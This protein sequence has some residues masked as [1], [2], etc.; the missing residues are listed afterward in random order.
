MDTR[1]MRA[2]LAGAALLTATLAIGAPPEAAHAQ[3]A[4]QAAQPG[5][6]QLSEEKLQ[7][8]AALFTA[9]TAARDEFQAQKARVHEEQARDRLR[10]EMDE[11]LA[12]LY[13]EHG[14]SQEEYDS[15][16]FLVSI[17]QAAR[18]RLDSILAARGGADGG[19][20]D[21]TDR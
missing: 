5:T 4:V 8:Y 18:T 16:T 21:G 2:R 15:I 19:D 9:I 11:R 14:M 7:Q 1:S 13:Q 17:D 10:Q 6:P 12:A 20:G 3:E